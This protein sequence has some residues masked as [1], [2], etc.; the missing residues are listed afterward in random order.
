MVAFAQGV[1][2]SLSSFDKLI[3]GLNDK[4]L[5]PVIEFCFIV[6][7]TVF[8]FGVMEYIRSANNPES[9]KKGQNHM[10][11][12]LLGLLIMFTVYGLINLALNTFGIK[13][14]TLNGKEQKFDPPTIQEIKVPEIKPK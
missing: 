13:G 5:N 10:L 3:F 11:F 9:R 7:L 6:A 4:L 14:A 8:L 1:D 12:G 2:E